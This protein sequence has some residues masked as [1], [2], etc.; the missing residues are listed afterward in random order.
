MK[1]TMIVFLL[2]VLHILQVEVS[3]QSANR[4]SMIYQA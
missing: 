3:A 4:I 1:Q 2:V